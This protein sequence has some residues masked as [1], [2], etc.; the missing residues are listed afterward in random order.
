MKN[1]DPAELVKQPQDVTES[2]YRRSAKDKTDT[3]KPAFGNADEE[4]K[5]FLNA[6]KRFKICLS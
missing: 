4:V 1:M 3:Q 2:P 6:T 5:Y